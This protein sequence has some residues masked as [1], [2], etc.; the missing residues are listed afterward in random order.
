[1]SHLLDSLSG[2]P[3][4]A[5]YLVTAAMVLLESLGL[6]VPGETALVA[7]TTL[8]THPNSAV[9]PWGVAAAGVVGAIVGDST[10][11]LV[12][13]R[14]GPPLLGRLSVR[15]P[16]HLSPAHVAY[17]R[18][19]FDRFGG[20]VVFSGRFVAL[21]RM[22]AGPVAGV[23]R[24]P[25][26]VFL[27]ANAAGALAWA[28]GLVALIYLVGTSVEHWFSGAAWVLLLVVLAG[29]LLGSRIIDRSFQQNV[30]RYA[31]CQDR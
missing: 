9:S 2:I 8:A 20:G 19:L 26:Q 25:Y 5:V 28:G 12:G 11:Y 27:A 29:G 14:Y 3:S 21:L 31:T 7:A 16:R 22:L 24:M 10:G 30:R 13:H 6:P 23:M 18:H 4:I 15:F 17:V 1:M